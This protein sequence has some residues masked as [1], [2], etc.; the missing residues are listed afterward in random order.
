MKTF[1]IINIK[2]KKKK[3]NHNNFIKSHKIR[4]K[5]L[6]FK[7]IIIKIKIYRIRFKKMLKKSQMNN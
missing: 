4:N 3:N 2:K 6:K 7:E 1:K 5:Q